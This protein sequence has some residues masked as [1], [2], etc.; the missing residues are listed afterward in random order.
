MKEVEHLPALGGTGHDRGS[1]VPPG[2][3]SPAAFPRDPLAGAVFIIPK[4]NC[5][6]ERAPLACSLSHC[7]A[8][9]SF[10]QVGYVL[11]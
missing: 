11:S 5:G 6:K 10:R 2:T 7:L 3:P 4:S 8:F 9:D 1:L